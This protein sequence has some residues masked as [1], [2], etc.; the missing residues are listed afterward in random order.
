MIIIFGTSHRKKALGQV[1][2][3][4]PRC[5]RDTIHTL[6]RRQSWFTLFFI[7]IFPVTKATYVARC[8]LCGQETVVDERG[9][10]LAVL[11]SPVVAAKASQVATTKKC[12]ACAEVIQLDARVC[13]YCGYQFSAEEYQAAQAVQQARAAQLALMAKHDALKRKRGFQFGCGL[14]L[15]VIGAL[16][17]LI[18]LIALITGPA[19]GTTVSR[20]VTAFLVFL[21]VVGLPP[22]GLGIFL[23][24][25]SSKTKGELDGLG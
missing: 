19:S 4:C 8:N 10:T 22:L 17:A 1:S 21:A 3:Q 13:R 7:P 24:L 9:Q 5:Q 2:R 20:H 23:V 14:I 11:R 15:L 25:R 18:T 12:P 16:A 6:E